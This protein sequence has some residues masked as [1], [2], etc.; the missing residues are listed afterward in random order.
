MIGESAAFLSGHAEVIYDAE[1]FFDGYTA[2]P[3]YALKTL[4][5][6][7]RRWRPLA[8]AVR[9]QRRHA[10]ERV[11]EVTADRH[12]RAAGPRRADWDPYSQ[13]RRTRGRQLAGRRRRR[14][15]RKCKAR[16]TASANVVATRT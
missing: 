10:S 8:G 16:S 13:R 3:E 2:N 11:A 7:G 5:V 1:H 4:A 14:R 15:Q 12:R 9:Y 6:G